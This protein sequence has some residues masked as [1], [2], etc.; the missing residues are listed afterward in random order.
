MQTN[1]SPVNTKHVVGRR[2]VHYSSLDEMLED[3]RR[4]S[5]DKVRTLG[6]WTPGQIFA[7]LAQSLDSS[8]DGSDFALPMPVRW[9]L[10][11]V[12]KRKFFT[13]SIPAGFTTSATYIPPA[14]SVADGIS[15]L[16]KAVTRQKQESSRATHPGFGKIS[17]DEWNDFH[18]RHAE[19]HMSFIV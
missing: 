13:Q 19:L 14:T 10:I 8:I 7:H 12:M 2:D 1:E 17:R 18:L 11:L 9:L 4:V 6:N 16:E 15:M 5:S 3:A